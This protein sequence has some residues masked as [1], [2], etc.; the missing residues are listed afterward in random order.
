LV[1]PREFAWNYA[2]RPEKVR[3]FRSTNADLDDISAVFR[4]RMNFVL[5]FRKDAAGS[6]RCS[7]DAPIWLPPTCGWEPEG[8]SPRDPPDPD[9]PCAWICHP[10]IDRETALDGPSVPI[11]GNTSV[12]LTMATMPWVPGSP[13]ANDFEDY[14]HPLDP[15]AAVG[16]FYR[17]TSQ[18]LVGRDF[19]PYGSDD[20]P[21]E[22]SPLNGCVPYGFVG[23]DVCVVIPQVLPEI[24]PVIPQ[25]IVA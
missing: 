2:C 6:R 20:F 21:C 9:F 8:C 14:G 10:N 19:A 24:G 17:Y 5:D 16:Q 15:F 7:V 4:D 1:A 18:P 25:E 13:P 22:L 23:M 3:T 12:C 11:L